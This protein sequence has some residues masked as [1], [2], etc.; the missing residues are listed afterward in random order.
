MKRNEHS[1][2]I[3]CPYCDY[4]FDN[5]H[6]IEAGYEDLGEIECDNCY[7]T[8]TAKRNQSFTI[9]TTQIIK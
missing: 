8:F 3:I 2:E 4:V 1:S 7:K 9:Y 6:E 5:S